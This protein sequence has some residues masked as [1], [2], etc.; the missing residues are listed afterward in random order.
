MP[1]LDVFWIVPPDPFFALPE[2]PVTVRPPL[3]P[4]LL[5]TI[6]LAGPDAAVP[7]E[8]LWNFSPVAPIVVP[9]TFSAV[10]VVVVSVFVTPVL[11]TL[12]VPPLPALNPVF[13][14]VERPRPPEK[15]TVPLSLLSRFTPVPPVLVTEPVNWTSP[16]V[17]VLRLVTW[18]VRPD[19]LLI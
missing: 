8:M 19:A 15:V 18:I 16:G 10:P 5:S 4:V 13:A 1:L 14:S 9:V 17:P 2:S 3:E 6:P 12:T 11:S 7:A